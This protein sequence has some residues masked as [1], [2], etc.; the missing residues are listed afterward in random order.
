LV[1]VTTNDEET[2]KVAASLQSDLAAAG[3]RVHIAVMSWSAW[4]TAV[5]QLDGPALSFTS[6]VAD[7]PDPV[8]FFEPRFHSRSIKP[9]DSSNDSFY[10]N[11]E[12]DRLLDAAR[13]EIDPARRAALYRR[14]ER[15]LHDDAPWI[16]DYHRVNT[17]VIQPYVRGYQQHPIWMRDYTST[18]LD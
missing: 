5:S 10:A 6:W 18:W 1:Y 2:E 13:G 12:A 8:N 4:A 17:E 9:A 3:V 15:I 11:P 7:F 16:W 14:V